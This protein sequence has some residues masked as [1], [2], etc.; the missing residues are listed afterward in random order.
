MKIN[1][2]LIKILLSLLLIY[3]LVGVFILPSIIKDQII[4]NAESSLQRKVSVESVSLNP[5]T[6]G[7]GID[8]LVIYEKA[9]E[10]AFVSVRNLELN[11]DPLNLLFAEIKIK[12]IEIT[13]PAVNIHRDAEG[14]FNF[15]D[16][17]VSKDENTTQE[18]TDKSE[19]PK[20]T[21]EKFSIQHGKLS[22]I[23]ETGSKVLKQALNSINFTVRDFSTGQDH[24]NQLSIRI[25]VDDGGYIDYRGK[26]SSLEPLRLKGSLE[27]HE[28]RLYTIWEHFRDKLGIVIADGIV[29]ASLEY[30]A[31]LSA[32]PMQVNINKYQ[33]Q[34]ER[35]LIQEKSSEENILKLPLFTLEGDANLTSSRINVNAID[36][37]G[38]WVKVQ[39]DD[40]GK[41]NWLDYFPASQEDPNS[42]ESESVEKSPSQ[43][44]W[45][46]HQFKLSESELVF[47]DGFNV[48]NAITQIDQI[49]LDVQ[50]LESLENSWAQS[51]LSLRINKTG[52]LSVNSKL[53]H[54]PL[55]VDTNVQMKDLALNT[56]QPYVN[57]FA[58]A[59]IKSGKFNL[60]AKV[61]LDKTTKV[62]AD[63]WIDKLN[64]AE[65]R[66]GK[67]FFSFSKLMIKDV[68]FSLDPNKIKIKNIDIYKPYARMKIDEKKVTNLDGLVVKTKQ[69]S[70]SKEKPVVKK[71]AE[72][73]FPV[74]ISRL[75]FKD[76]TGEFSDL[77]LPLPFKTDIHS[78]NGKI[79]AVGNIAEIKSSV[80][81]DGVV[82]EYGLAK[83]KGKL[84]SSNPK[85]FTDIALKFQNI[86]MTNLS[87]YTGKFIG[88]KLEKG[89]MNVELDYKINDSIMHGGNR[90]VLKQ[91]TLGE[92]VESEDAISAP[93]G[94]A[95]ALL[96]DSDGVIDLDV[97]VTGDV[98]A[99]DFAVGHV[100]WTAFKNLIV[101]V[102]TAPFR[103]LGDMLGMSAQE[104]ENIHFERG[105]AHLLPPEKE[106]LD[107]L[108][109]VFE[110]KK[111]LV[112]K[113]AGSYDESR[114]L[115]AMKTAKM[116]QEALVKLE[117]NTTDIA[118]MDRD[119]YD[120][121]MEDLYVVHFGDEKLDAL[122]DAVDAKDIN[123]NAKKEMLREEFTS[124]LR[125]DQNITQVD[126]N[127]L[128]TMRAK[129]I[130]SHLASK[131]VVAERLNLLESVKVQTTAE[132]SEYIPTKLELGAR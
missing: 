68:D 45:K 13:T 22:L 74:F 5:Y 71:K 10:E 125:Q 104:L 60:E 63:T 65:R 23:D 85:A 126:L 110:S 48:V 127:K 111:M 117:D 72:N 70:E 40:C 77:S 76:G 99:P 98:D 33:L 57:S 61:S 78:L 95:I 1:K 109:G 38:L 64:I 130:L 96:K 81:I 86:D 121:L 123:S 120:D 103:F 21:V 58:N 51:A 129:S 88:N 73:P 56:F 113:V 118:H 2:T 83:I 39:R 15:S 80:D 112:L 101:G 35:L 100:V 18:S 97:P 34:L 42:K 7:M 29:N 49:N 91:L 54:T 19:P 55:K 124:A 8:N 115:L 47:E 30:S 84:L 116:Y 131:G 41:I 89:K 16:L 114:D 92:S 67:T 36:V 3:G 105:K 24:D 28:G 17:L 132:D 50:G 43:L 75:N 14:K 106:K 9:N 20:I 4:I 79:L 44:Y 27:L 119:E 87:P 93:V 107:K 12:F 122:E 102:A 69:N 52:Q 62:I 53:R 59:D 94:L 108:A 26:V 46:V 25:D 82:D 128:A 90:V 32:Q 11:I 6:F 31:D 66:E 37:N